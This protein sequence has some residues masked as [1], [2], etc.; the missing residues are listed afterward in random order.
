MFYG[1]G[2]L[3]TFYTNKMIQI[4]KDEYPDSDND[5]LSKKL[6]ISE[7]A[8]KTKASRL[9]IKKS[10]EYMDKIY[11]NMQ[12]HRK[13]QQ[14]N[15]YKVYEMSNIERNIIIGSLIGDGTL[16]IYGRSKNASYRESTGPSQREYRQWKVRM[17]KNL[18]FKI[19]RDGSIYSPSHPIYTDLYNLFYPNGK[20][21]LPKE[22]LNLLNHPI[23]L[24]C[25]YMDDGSL[26]INNYK[27][28]KN[29][30]LFPQIA[31]Y[32]QS[33][34]KEENLLLKKHIQNTFNIK[35]KLS[36]RKD[37]SNYILKINKI[38]EVYSFINIVKPYV[39]Q[40][41]CMGY[42][43]DVD[44]KL[45]ETKKRYS[46]KYKYRNI[47][48]ANKIAKDISYSSYEEDKIIELHRKG[49][50]YTEIASCLDRPYYGLYDKVKRMKEEGKI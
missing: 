42:K 2:V 5:I 20:K 4:I 31:L 29:I 44:K 49:Y 8:L 19:K 14:A 3:T 13:I 1:G 6:G 21:I 47:K 46:K 17:L 32:S 50:N 35:F 39:E 37:G 43:I 24:A 45:T 41:P 18:D 30:T 28:N 12:K 23:G 10:E 27:Y 7:P 26:V 9:G 40:I 22:G 36:K 11:K 48:L 34:T 38:N 16:S 25:L 33:F 15:S